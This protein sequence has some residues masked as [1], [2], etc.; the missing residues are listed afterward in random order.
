MAKRTGI[1]TLRTIAKTMCKLV[2]SYG[3]TI[4]KI[5]PENTALHIAID[6]ADAACHALFVQLDELIE[7]GD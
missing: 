4:K 7:Y 2:L 3:E 6:T 1:T 5:Y